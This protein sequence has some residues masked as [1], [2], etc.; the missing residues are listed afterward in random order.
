MKPNRAYIAPSITEAQKLLKGLDLTFEQVAQICALKPRAVRE[1]FFVKPI[2]F[3][4]LYTLV[5]HVLG[6]SI[7]QSDWRNQIQ[8]H[9]DH[10]QN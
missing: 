2:Q 3:T 5:H 9:L 4:M 10:A 7:S 6:V 1:N 8:E